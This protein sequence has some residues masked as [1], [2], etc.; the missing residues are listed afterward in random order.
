[1]DDDARARVFG[2]HRGALF[3]AAYGILGS[4]ADSEDAVQETWLRWR[5]K[6]LGAIERPRSYLLAAVTRTALNIV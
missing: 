1:M 4:V 2:E 3:R 6:D 5:G